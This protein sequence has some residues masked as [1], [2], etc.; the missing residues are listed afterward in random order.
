MQGMYRVKSALDAI[1]I[2]EIWKKILYSATALHK[3]RMPPLPYHVSPL[4]VTGM[5]PRIEYCWRTNVESPVS[6]EE[7][8]PIVARMRYLD[9]PSFHGDL[10]RFEDYSTSYSSLLWG[11]GK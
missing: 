7:R 11:S 5:V 4:P 2:R 3:M 1:E 10:V 9:K 8:K 6:K